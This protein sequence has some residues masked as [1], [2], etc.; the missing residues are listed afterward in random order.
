MLVLDLDGQLGHGDGRVQVLGPAN[1]AAG[2]DEDAAGE[3]GDLVQFPT[4]LAGPGGGQ[5]LAAL[6]GVGGLPDQPDHPGA[7]G[8]LVRLEVV[9]RL[10]EA[11][12]RVGDDLPPFGDVLLDDHDAVGEAAAGLNEGLAEQLGGAGLDHTLEEGLGHGHGL[13]VLGVVVLVAEQ[14]LGVHGEHGLGDRG[15]VDRNLVVL[16]LGLEVRVDDRTGVDAVDALDQVFVDHLV[17]VA[18]VEVELATQYLDQVQAAVVLPD[19]AEAGVGHAVGA[20]AGSI[21]LVVVEVAQGG[22]VVAAD[23]EDDGAVLGGGRGQALFVAGADDLGLGGQGREHCSGE[24]VV[25]VEL[26]AVGDDDGG[27]GGGLGHDLLLSKLQAH[28]ALVFW[29]KEQVKLTKHP[30]TKISFCQGCRN[31]SIPLH[32]LTYFKV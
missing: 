16:D 27:D 8:G 9:E 29:G 19:E 24:H 31:G 11:A 30:S 18:V 1:E 21:F 2:V 14:G 32:H 25:G 12:V 5:G 10:G 7:G 3:A 28:G 15:H 26:T 22:I 17:E 6:E 13:E 23:V 4:P 20:G